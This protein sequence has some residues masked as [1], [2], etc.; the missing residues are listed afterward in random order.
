MR[1]HRTT[2]EHCASAEG[3]VSWRTPVRPGAHRCVLAHT[4]ASV[5]PTTSGPAACRMMRSMPH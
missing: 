5:A 1:L 3:G 2:P 4:M